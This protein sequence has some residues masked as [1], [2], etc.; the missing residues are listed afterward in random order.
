MTATSSSNGRA[1]PELKLGEWSVRVDI[2]PNSYHVGDAIDFMRSLPDG[3]I[4][5]VATSPPYNKSFR[6]RGGRKSNWPNSQLMANNYIGYDDDMPE[7]EYVRWQREFLKE[8]V[9]LVGENGV[10]LYNIGRR[11]FKKREDRRQDIIADFPVRQTIIWN[12]GSSNNQGGKRPTIFPPIYEL[13]YVIAGDGWKL[14][15]KHL[16]EM[17]KWGDVW[18]IPFETGNPHPAPFPLELARRLVKTVDGVVLDP[19]AGSG[20]I[21]VAASELGY[22]YLLNDSCEKYKTMFEDRILRRNEEKT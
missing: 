10:V 13:I 12:R 22:D 19:F 9:R 20:T 16:G 21:G 17:R 11:I 3:L 6:N 4:D 18:R 2:E 1:Q 8:A 7:D 5:G 14:P 15:Q